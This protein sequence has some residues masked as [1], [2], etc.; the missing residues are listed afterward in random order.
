MKDSVNMKKKPARAMT[1]VKNELKQFDK[2]FDKWRDD[3]A[4]DLQKVREAEALNERLKVMGR[5]IDLL[6]KK[7][8]LKR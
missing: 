6:Q 1:A 3:K 5:K 4:L 8:K 2:D 7:K